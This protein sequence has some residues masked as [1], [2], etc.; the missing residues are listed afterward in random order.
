[1]KKKLNEN[2]IKNE[3][4]QS[5]F[6]QKPEKSSIN[7]INEDNYIKS[8][9]PSDGTVQSRN[10]ESM[11]PRFNETMPPRHLPIAGYHDDLLE[12]IRQALIPFGKEAATF[13]FTQTEKD[14]ITE[15]IYLYNNKKIR[16]S[17]N[18]ITRVA[19]NFI[20]NDHKEFGEDSILEKVLKLLNN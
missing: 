19:I 11:K 3:L 16:T 7:E 9:S 6:F 5:A 10:N 13:R 15:L 4:A 18:E 20:I 12:G 14:E 1:M 17:A 8:I 2:A